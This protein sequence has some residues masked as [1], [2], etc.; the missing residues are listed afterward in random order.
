MFI[1]PRERVV[2]ELTLAEIEAGLTAKNGADLKHGFR[3]NPDAANLVAADPPLA[4]LSNGTLGRIFETGSVAAEEV[5]FLYSFD[6]G[7]T[8]REFQNRPIHSIAG[9]GIANGDR[10]SRPFAKPMVFEPRSSIR[11]QV[12]ELSGPAGTLFIVLQGYKILG[13]GRIPG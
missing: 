12:E 8:G 4:Q 10:P 6:V 7:S 9:L 2:S 13:T 1:V 5:S 11:L 3:V